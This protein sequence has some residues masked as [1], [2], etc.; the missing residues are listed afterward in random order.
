MRARK[1][2]IE[3][4]RGMIHRLCALRPLW[5]LALPP[6]LALEQPTQNGGES[7]GPQCPSLGDCLFIRNFPRAPLVLMCF[8]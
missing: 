3:P 6:L 1:R 8:P 5:R 4:R 2:K 7:P